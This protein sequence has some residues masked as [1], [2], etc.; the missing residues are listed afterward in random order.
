MTEDDIRDLFREM[1]DESVPVDSL[2]RVRVRVEDRIRRRAPWKIAS[3]V[4]AFAALVV[5][6]FVIQIHPAVRK[7][8][9]PSAAA[10]HA[11]PPPEVETA[12]LENLPLSVRPAI[13]RKTHK[14]PTAPLTQPVSTIRI[15]TPDPDV[16]ILLVSQ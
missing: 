11:P 10:K 9:S 1:R 15:E 2:V 14:P 3:L 6:A 12:P 4:T 7:T 8:A 13:E 16:V 5:V